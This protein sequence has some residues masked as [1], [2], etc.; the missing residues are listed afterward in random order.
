MNLKNLNLKK[1]YDSDTDNILEDFYIPSL[2]ESFLYKRLAGFFSSSA[3]A[4][5]AKGITKLIEN[6]GKM[7]LITCARLQKADIEMIEK[8]IEK[9]EEIIF[10]YFINDLKNLNDEFILDHVKA[11]GWM[12]ANKKLEIKI[13]LVKDENGKILDQEEIDKKGIFHQKVGIFED[14]QGNKLSFS[15]SQN[16]SANAWINNI[17]E[18]KIFR[19][20]LSEEQKYFEADNNKFNKYWSDTADRTKIIDLPIAI[21]EKLI[22]IAPKDI[23]ELKLEKN[24]DT[25]MSGKIE[26]KKIKLRDYQDE[27]IEQ[28]VNNEYKGIFEMAT[29]TGKT[30][31]AL[32]CAKKIFDKYSNNILVISTPTTHMVE[33]WE[34]DISDF[35]FNNIPIIKAFSDYGYSWGKDMINSIN[36]IRI[37]K[38]NNIIIL[39]THATFASKKFIGII[40][41][42]NS[43]ISLF[44]V[45][46]EVH[47]VGAPQRSEGMIDKYIYRLG[48]SAT[49]SRW[50]DSEGTELIFSYFGKTVF[51]YSLQKAIENGFLTPYEYKPIFL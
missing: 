31:T 25:R 18:I 4:V 8:V 10:K 13:A 38:Y 11:L 32:G 43:K 41:E 44:L 48:L 42:I 34:K 5:A 40:S 36:K 16:E 51:E 19:N 17:E 15:G 24:Y 27:A 33:Q 7:E 1:S 3:L 12:I 30:F 39:T 9:P 20:W 2:S 28:W 46:D 35:G 50:L 47:G 22:Q 45:S 49:P 21:K 26:E 37:G 14:Q 23:K 6:D 29:G